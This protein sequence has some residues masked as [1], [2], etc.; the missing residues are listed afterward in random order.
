MRRDLPFIGTQSSWWQLNLLNDNHEW[1]QR[2][3]HDDCRFSVT[4]LVCLPCTKHPSW[5]S[6]KAILMG[7]LCFICC[8]F[9]TFGHWNY[10]LFWCSFSAATLYRMLHGW[11]IKG[12]YHDDYVSQLYSQ[13]YW[14]GYVWSQHHDVIKLKYFPR[15]WP[16]VWGI[17]RSPVI[18]PHKGQWRRALMF[19]LICARINGWVNNRKA[20]DLRRHQAHY[21]ITVMEQTSLEA[22]S[23]TQMPWPLLIHRKKLPLA[24]ILCLSQVGLV[25][26]ID[27][28]G[29]VKNAYELLNIRA[30]K[31]SMLHKIIYFNVWV[32]YFVWNFKGHH[33][34]S[35]QN[36]LPILW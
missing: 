16:F 27:L 11:L 18:S 4:I 2:W 13:G 32:R 21:D 15:Y 6:W 12:L 31:I 35:T 10:A 17:H 1:R 9:K 22:G 33:W 28:G 29:R 7:I 30:L 25:C 34:N 36:I 3:H 14:W 23:A 5:F 8:A 24:S 26:L 20:G 19:S